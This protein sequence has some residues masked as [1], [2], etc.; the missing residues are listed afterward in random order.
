VLKCDKVYGE[1]F[2]KKVGKKNK[3]V[4]FGKRIAP[5]F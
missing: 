2:L 5:G 3:S 1:I 4:I